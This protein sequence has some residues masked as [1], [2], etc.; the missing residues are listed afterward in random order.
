MQDSVK[1]VMSKKKN[2]YKLCLYF[3]KSSIVP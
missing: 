2:L 3:L 1:N